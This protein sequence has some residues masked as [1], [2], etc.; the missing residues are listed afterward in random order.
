MVKVVFINGY[1]ASGKSTIVNELK[2]QNINC[3]I[4]CKDEIKEILFDQFGVDNDKNGKQLNNATLGILYRLLAEHLR[5]RSDLI[6]EGN[7]KP[8]YDQDMIDGIIDG[9]NYKVLQIMLVAN[10]KTLLSRDSLR[11]KSGNRKIGH[12]KLDIN[13]MYMQRE[14]VKPFN[15]KGSTIEHYDTSDFRLSDYATIVFKIKSFLGY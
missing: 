3:P 4:I 10:N 5:S 11:H 7:F 1:P 13:M 8:I 14:Q 15:I 2:K 6:V 9:N 12:S